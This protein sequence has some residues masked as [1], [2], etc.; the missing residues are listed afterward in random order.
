VKST[1]VGPSLSLII[2]NG[3]LALGTWQGVI[4]CE[5]DGP[6]NRKVFIQLISA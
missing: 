4:F 3:K 6:R 1:L 2:D 5:F